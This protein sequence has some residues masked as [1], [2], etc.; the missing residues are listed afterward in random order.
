MIRWNNVHDQEIVAVSVHDFSSQSINLTQHVFQG[1]W[2]LSSQVRFSLDPVSLRTNWMAVDLEINNRGWRVW[3]GRHLF[4]EVGSEA[5]RDRLE[6]FIVQFADNELGFANG[7]GGNALHRSE[8]RKNFGRILVSSQDLI[9]TLEPIT[10]LLIHHRDHMEQIPTA[11]TFRYVS[12]THSVN[13]NRVLVISYV[14]SAFSMGSLRCDLGYGFYVGDSFIFLIS[15]ECESG[16]DDRSRGI[17]YAT[18]NLRL[19]SQ[20]VT[21]SNIQIPVRQQISSLHFFIQRDGQISVRELTLLGGR[22]SETPNNT[23]AL[24]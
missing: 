3:P 21:K 1:Y 10:K 2:Q 24:N 11:P 7:S 20:L 19:F 5:E 16:G 14:R 8:M 12:D 18:A 13:G 4:A 17:A 22:V 6:R 9:L 23:R 15:C